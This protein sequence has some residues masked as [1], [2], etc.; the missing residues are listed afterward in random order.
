MAQVSILRFTVVGVLL[1]AGGFI[2][3]AAARQSKPIVAINANIATYQIDGSSLKRLPQKNL[4]FVT[5]TYNNASIPCVIMDSQIGGQSFAPAISCAW[6]PEA[7][8]AV[9]KAGE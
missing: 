9:D 6:P 3:Y 5:L 7:I 8:A 1:L 2:G 4:S